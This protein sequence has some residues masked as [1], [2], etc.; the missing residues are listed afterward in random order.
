[1]LA[2]RPASILDADRDAHTSI[3]E[4][5][6]TVPFTHYCVRRA[7]IAQ[8]RHCD[9]GLMLQSNHVCTM[10]LRQDMD[11]DVL[12]LLLLP[13]SLERFLS[14]LGPCSPLTGL[15]KG[16]DNHAHTQ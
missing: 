13:R 7:S 9:N 6:G 14:S 2:Q 16:R 11:D 1:M 8:R 4:D 15:A 10:Y 5:A 3:S 12:L